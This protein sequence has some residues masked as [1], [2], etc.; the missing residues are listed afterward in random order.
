VLQNVE[1]ALALS[2]VWAEERRRRALDALGQVGLREL[3]NNKAMQLSGGQMQRVAIARALVN[4]PDIILADEPTGALDSQTGTMIMEIFGEIAQSKLVIM[5][6]HNRDLAFGYSN[7]IIELLDG[8]VLSDNNPPQKRRLA[9]APKKSGKTAMSPFTALSLSFRNLLTKKG[10]TFTTAL[11]GGI[12]IIGLGLVLALSS[13]LSAY[14]GDMQSDALSGYPISITTGEENVVLGELPAYTK[15]PSGDIMYCYD[16]GAYKT[17]HTNEITEEYLKYIGGLPYRYPDAL[18]TISYSRGVRINLINLLPEQPDA[19]IFSTTGMEQEVGYM[20]MSST[21]WQ[22]MPENSEFILSQYDLIGQD[23]RLPV[24]ENEI[25]LVVDEYNRMDV[26]FFEK[27]GIDNGI[28]EYR[29]TDFI[30]KSIAKQISND[31]FYTEQDGAF[32]AAAEE[33]YAYLYHEADGTMLT[34]TGILHLKPTAS[35]SYFN[36]GVVCTSALTDKIIREAADSRIAQAQAAADYDVLTGKPFATPEDQEKQLRRL[37]VD[38]IPTAIDIYP[39]DFA[40]K[41]T[42]IDYLDEYN[43]GRPESQWIVYT[44]HADELTSVTGNLISTVYYALILFAAISLVVSGIMIAI[45]TYVSVIERTREIGI[46]KGIGARKTDISRVF[47]AETAIIG[48]VAG[49]IGIIVSAILV[50]PINRLIS[51]AAGVESIA[52]FTPLHAILLIL[53][54]V[55]LALIAGFLPAR[56]AAGKDPVEALRAD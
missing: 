32:T 37:G 46:L 48:F 2:G 39:R 41:D 50:I 7:R 20:G 18:N 54:S 1:I 52:A 14:M 8:K 9:Q 16:E 28:E 19:A 25:A 17:D 33:D 12:G 4:D 49:V 35:G 11:A 24:G 15:Y 21:Y 10:R 45:I 53:G 30:G 26:D 22:E 31:L 51:G 38:V 3:A 55:A 13:G 56:A 29:L 44:D 40:G 36:Q 6:T 5:V 43:T 34:V 42:V 27:L 47:E 23:S